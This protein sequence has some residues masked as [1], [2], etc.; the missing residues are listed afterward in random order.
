MS[1]APMPDHRRVDD[2]D[3]L[4]LFNA[5]G[6]IIRPLRE[7][8]LVTDFEV[9]GGNN[10]I[11]VALPDGSHLVIASDEDLP[12]DPSQVKGWHVRRH[13]D[14]NPTI[15]DVIYDSTLTGSDCLN[16]Q[17]R[18]PLFAAID[19]YLGVRGLT[20]SWRST[21]QPAVVKR[22]HIT[23]DGTPRTP[24]LRPYVGRE[25]ATHAY[26]VEHESAYK[27]GW[28]RIWAHPSRDWPRSM[29]RR[30]DSLLLLGVTAT[31]FATGADTDHG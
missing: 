26:T 19:G 13:H 25:Y 28:H 17:L 20:E 15:S 30:G 14:D 24:S 7:R 12:S 5:Y 11:E 10:L 22:Q 29:W 1:L 27:E 8:G 3:W 21:I 31:E 4:R 6:H 18:S 9:C 23:D 2:P 16:R